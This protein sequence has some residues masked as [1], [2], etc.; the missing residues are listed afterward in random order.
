M[1]GR[2][3]GEDVDRDE[4][5]DSGDL[6]VG[7]SLVVTEVEAQSFGCDERTLLLHMVTEHLAQRPV[8][9]VSRGVVAPDGGASFG[10][11]RGDG[12]LTDLDLAVHRLEP[13]AHDT[14]SAVHRVD[15]VHATGGCGDGAGV[16]DLATGLGVEGRAV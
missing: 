7:E 9:Q 8:Q 2:R 13:M 1:S 15:D 14:G 10:V 5:L 12:R 4:I 11:D 3:V 16:S 6:L